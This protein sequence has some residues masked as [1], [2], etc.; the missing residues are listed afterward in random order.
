MSKDKDKNTNTSKKDY[1]RVAGGNDVKVANSVIAGSTSGLI[2]RT[3]IAPFDFVK[4]RLQ[5]TPYI[6]VV[7][8]P[9]TKLY[10]P[11]RGKIAPRMLIPKFNIYRTLVD[12]IEREGIK[13]L[14]KGNLP[15][16]MMYVI[17]GSIQF[18]SYSVYSKLLQKLYPV[19]SKS[20]KGKADVRSVIIGGLS[21]VTGSVCSYPFD[22]LRTTFIANKRSEMLHFFRS[23]RD[24]WRIDGIKGFYNG[25]SIAVMSIGASTAIIFG[26][27]ENI[28]IFCERKLKEKEGAS[29]YAILPY[30]IL[31]KGSSFVGGT[32]S[33]IMVFPLDT[34]RRRF[35]LMDDSA[36]FRTF[37]DVHAD[38]KS[39][40]L[41]K[42]Y[43]QE[44]NRPRGSHM[45]I[46]SVVHLGIELI[47]NEGILSLY[48]GLM[49]GLFKSVPATVI[50]LWTY[51]QAMR[52]LDR[53]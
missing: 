41:V 52:L 44:L 10:V 28:K 31:Y 8:P 19:H 42:K 17:Y 40:E 30:E 24:I 45:S 27:Y 25:C 12:V 2:S 14:W 18:G 50:S 22:V 6:K 4:I 15:G 34:I 9:D 23:I 26:T 32:L 35:L 43:R 20:S 5:V 29:T 3:V 51:E 39:M 13:S 49:I 21:G 38:K 37:F 48:K 53:R 33:K 16:S 7:V 47:R 46:S 11:T 36:H 1:L